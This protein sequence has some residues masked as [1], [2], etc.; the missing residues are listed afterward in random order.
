MLIVRRVRPPAA[1][2][3]FAG[4]A[5][6]TLLIACGVLA[7]GCFVLAALLWWMPH[8]E[9]VAPSDKRIALDDTPELK[10]AGRQSRALRRARTAPTTRSTASR[11]ESVDI[12]LG[13]GEGREV[14][15][16]LP[17]GVERGDALLSLGGASHRGQGRGA[18]GVRG[19]AAAARPAPA[20]LGDDVVLTTS[21]KNT[22]DIGG[23]FDGV[24]HGR[25]PGAHDAARGDRARPDEGRHLRPHRRQGRRLPLQLGDAGARFVIVKPVRLRNGYVIKRSASGGRAYMTVTN[26]T[27]A[28]AM[29]VLTRTQQQAQARAGRLRAQG[30]EGQDQGHPRRQV[31]AVGL[32]RR[33]L[34]LDDAR[35]LRPRWSTSAGSQPLKFDTTA[36]TESWTVYWS[37]TYY[38]YSQKH[39]QTTTHWTNWTVTLGTGES[40]YTKLVTEGGFPQ[41]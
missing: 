26:E 21:V 5:A 33:R 25:R 7:A 29:V 12:P 6:R 16:S 40:K 11:Q 38:N 4:S 1:G 18:A 13:A 27:G 14:T 17:A 2:R 34:Q 36:S 19:R 24:A 22:G 20:K 37:D 10:V 41:L 15:L 35:L 32:L 3:W 23:T 8:Y 9:V 30:R 28:D 31:R 39:S